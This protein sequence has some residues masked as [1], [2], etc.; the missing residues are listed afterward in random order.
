MQKS[1]ILRRLLKDKSVPRLLGFAFVTFHSRESKNGRRIELLRRILF[2]Q[3]FSIWLAPFCDGGLYC[4]SLHNNQH[5]KLRTLQ[6]TRV[7]QPS[8]IQKSVTL[9]STRLTMER[10]PKVLKTCSYGLSYSIHFGNI[11]SIMRAFHEPSTE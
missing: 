3:V 11:I 7:V 8:S 5:N 9:S 1:L 6:S 2:Q 10:H 4:S